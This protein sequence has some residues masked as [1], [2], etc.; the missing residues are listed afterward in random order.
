MPPHIS[1]TARPVTVGG[2]VRRRWGLEAWKRRDEVERAK[3]RVLLWQHFPLEIRSDEDRQG[4]MIREE[5][6]YPLA[7][8]QTVRQPKRS[9]YLS[10]SWANT[11]VRQHWDFSMCQF[12]SHTEVNEWVN[13]WPMP[14]S[15]LPRVH[16]TWQLKTV[17]ELCY[18][19][20]KNQ[21]QC[22]IIR[23]LY[24]ESDIS[25]LSEFLTRKYKLDV[26]V[27]VI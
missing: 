24:Q 9:Y 25:E 18:V 10:I 21:N 5:V 2:G 1:Y 6:C 23:H 16:V 17:V 11:T 26:G 8:R 7:V 19:R 14:C 12:S 22:W 15:C 20:V 27:N 13:D 3:E 4:W